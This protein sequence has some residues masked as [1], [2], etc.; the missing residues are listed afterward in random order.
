MVLWTI[1][2]L[3]LL[4]LFVSG[5]IRRFSNTRSCVH[6]REIQFLSYSLYFVSDFRLSVT[7]M[8]EKMFQDDIGACDI[9]VA[10]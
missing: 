3:A 7:E 5:I 8:T 1:Q 9:P 2:L 10:C 4:C 6:K